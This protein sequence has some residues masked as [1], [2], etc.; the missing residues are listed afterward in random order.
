[1][2]SISP[3]FTDSGERDIVPL[4][5]L[6]GG[7]VKGSFADIWEHMPRK[8]EKHSC[9]NILLGAGILL[10][11]LQAA[12]RRF[13]WELPALTFRFTRPR[14]KRSAPR[15]RPGA[16]RKPELPEEKETV[17][18]EEPAAEPEDEDFSAAL[19][20]AKRK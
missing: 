17:P 19:K 20:Q 8:Q 1:M 7:R 14:F 3:E 5:R 15:R 16:E 18:P 10:I 12:L 13:G 9:V 2:R 4:V 6:T 11:L